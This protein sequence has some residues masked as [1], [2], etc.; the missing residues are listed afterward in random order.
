LSLTQKPRDFSDIKR[1]DFPWF[2][3]WQRKE[4]ELCHEVMEQARKAQVPEERGQAVDVQAVAL[5]V[6]R[7]VWEEEERG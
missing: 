6:A 3:G 2:N 4:A 7:A 1:H 5:E